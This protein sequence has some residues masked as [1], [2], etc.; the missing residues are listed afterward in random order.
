MFFAYSAKQIVGTSNYLNI[1]NTRDVTPVGAILIAIPASVQASVDDQFFL[2]TAT[3]SIPAG[4]AT[5]LPVPAEAI[6]V[7]VV[8]NILANAIDT[9]NG[10][11]ALVTSIPSIQFVINDSAFAGGEDRES[12]ENRAIRFQ[13]EIQGLTRST[14]LGIIASVLALDGIKSVSLRENFPSAGQITVI[15]DDGSG[16]LSAAKKIEVEKVLDGDPDD[17]ANFPGVRSA[18]ITAN[19]EAP[20]VIPVDVVIV[21]TRVGTLSDE[22]EIQTAVQSAIEQYINTRKL[23]EDVIRSEIIKVAKNANPS[24]YDVSLTIPLANT[25]IDDSSLARTGSGTGASVI[26]SLITIFST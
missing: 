16:L 10:K 12:E 20:F 22:D 3:S 26:T 17:L 15:A 24:V 9:L 23:G 7:G 18:G 4:D 6:R 5:S 1:A 14:V 2:T 13:A 25:V 19:V 21:I 11:G 8:G